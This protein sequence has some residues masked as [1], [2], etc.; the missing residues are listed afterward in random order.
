MLPDGVGEVLPFRSICHG[1]DGQ[2]SVGL[3]AKLFQGLVAVAPVFHDFDVE[4]E[5][6]FLAGEFLDVFAGFDADFLDG[7]ALVAYEDGLLRLAL[8]KDDGTDVVDTFFLFVAF[9]GHLAAVRDFLLVIEQ[10]FLADDF[11]DKETHGAVGELVFGEVRGILGQEVENVVEDGVDVEPF[12]GGAGNDDGTR[13]LV[14]PVSYLV[15]DGLL[16]A[17]VDFVDGQDDR[18][19]TFDDFSEHLLVFEGLANLGH[20]QEEVG[21]FE[22]AIDEAHHLLVQL[23]VGIDDAGGVGIDYLEVFAIDDAHDAVAGGLGL[24]GDD[25]EPFAHEGVHEGGLTHVGVADDVYKS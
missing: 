5:E 24:A 16:V 18:S 15:L 2:F 9:D 10:Q 11:A 13:D 7:F 21:V 17:E 3:V 19:L 23:V 12:G 20:Q 6:T 4:V 8:D 25:A 22:G 14:L 1:V